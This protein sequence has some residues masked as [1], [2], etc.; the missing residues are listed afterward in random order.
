MRTAA[1]LLLGAAVAASAEPPPD[2]IDPEIEHILAVLEAREKATGAFRA[3]YFETGSGTAGR[4]MGPR[5]FAWSPQRS[6]YRGPK[7]G[8]PYGI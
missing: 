7:V 5:F 1:L 3:E 8:K 6:L 4:R 2:A